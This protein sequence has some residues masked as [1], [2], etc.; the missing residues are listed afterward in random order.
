[1]D[2][3]FVEVVAAPGEH[4]GLPGVAHR[5]HRFGDEPEHTVRGPVAVLPHEQRPGKALALVRPVGVRDAYPLEQ[6]A[7]LATG[8]ALARVG[9]DVRDCGNRGGGLDLL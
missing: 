1:M 3:D 8:Q 6:E 2:E 7:D 5:C 4:P 9:E